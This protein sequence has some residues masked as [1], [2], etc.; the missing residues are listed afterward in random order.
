MTA[1]GQEIQSNT[2]TIV[3]GVY[4]DVGSQIEA[5][6]ADPK[7][8]Y[9][10]GVDKVNNSLHFI[11]LTTNTVEKTI[12]VGSSPVDLDINLQGTTLY[13]ANFGSTQIARS[14]SHP[15]HGGSISVD[16]TVG[17]WD[18]IPTAWPARRVTRW[19]SPAWT[20]GTISSWSTP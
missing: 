16:T 17:T 15:H 20:S 19:C 5:M 10:Y 7:R 2:Q 18:G 14:I 13:V 8:P 6:M 4:I 3:T 12:F 1:S 9:I 11:N